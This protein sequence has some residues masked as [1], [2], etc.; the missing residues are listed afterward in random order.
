M[1][2][3]ALFIVTSIVSIY[4]YQK[5]IDILNEFNEYIK[6]KELKPS[7]QT[8]ISDDDSWNLT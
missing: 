6:H 4:Y 1:I 3:K 2:W 5:Y 7:E 8:E